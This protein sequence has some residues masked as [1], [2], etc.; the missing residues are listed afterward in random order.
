MPRMRGS[1]PRANWSTPTYCAFAPIRRTCRSATRAASG[2]ENKLAELVAAKTGRKSVAY[3]W[4]PMVM[5]FVRNTLR[6]NLCDVIIGYA[7]GR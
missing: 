4:Y 6:A 7:A 3:T 2:F 1:A 5:G